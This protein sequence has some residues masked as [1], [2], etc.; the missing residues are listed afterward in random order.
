MA[1]IRKILPLFLLLAAAL[2]LG[3][4]STT[5]NSIADNSN[6]VIREFLMNSSVV[7]SNTVPQQQLSPNEITVNKGDTVLIHFSSQQ[8]S[9][10]NGT[11]FNGSGFNGSGFNRTD[12]NRSNSGRIGFNQSRNV[13]GGRPGAAG[14]RG[15]RDFNIDQLNVHIP[16]AQGEVTDIQ[17]VASQS[18]DF[19]Y[20]VG[21]PSG[22]QNDSGIL[23]V[24]DSVK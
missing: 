12:F 17:F 9:G 21:M 2:V 19:P 8:P 5:Q 16:I 3:C 10:F 13:S 23:H 15:T 22:S 4:T 7:F 11:G 1:P 18:G 14:G 24:I 6:G 20:Y